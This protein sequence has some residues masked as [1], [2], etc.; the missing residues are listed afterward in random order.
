MGSWSEKQ[1]LVPGPFGFLVGGWWLGSL[2]KVVRRRVCWVVERE[3]KK[4]TKR[5]KTMGWN[6]GNLK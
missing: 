3:M 4:K 5:K 6:A 2:G 1:E